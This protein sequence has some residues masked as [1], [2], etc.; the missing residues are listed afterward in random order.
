[1]VKNS[2]IVAV[3]TPIENA[4]AAVVSALVNTPRDIQYDVRLT[5]LLAAGTISGG[6]TLE[7]ISVGSD[8]TEY[9]PADSDDNRTIA[10]LSDALTAS[11]TISVSKGIDRVAGIDNMKFALTNNSGVSI[12]TASIEVG[13]LQY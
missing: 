1:M 8:A 2:S 12:T 3:A 4:A 10:L 6:I 13:K 11:T 9:Y 5:M 7:L